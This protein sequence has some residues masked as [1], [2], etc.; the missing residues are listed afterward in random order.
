MTHSWW[1]PAPCLQLVVYP[2]PVLPL[3]ACH[4][5]N[6]SEH[7]VVQGCTCSVPCLLQQSLQQYHHIMTESCLS[8]GLYFMTWRTSRIQHS[9][10]NQVMAAQSPSLTEPCSYYH[11]LALNSGS[12]TMYILLAPIWQPDEVSKWVLG[13]ESE[14]KYLTWMNV[15]NIIAFHQGK[16]EAIPYPRHW[17]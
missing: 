9:P 2:P 1:D 8:V 17:L 14:R 7:S 10:Q 15:C 6:P 16:M 11:S 3:T 5:S 12:I 4:G 13:T